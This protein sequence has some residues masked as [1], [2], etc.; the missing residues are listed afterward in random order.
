[1]GGIVCPDLAWCVSEVSVLVGEWVPFG[2]NQIVALN[3]KL[4]EFRGIRQRGRSRVAWAMLTT[5]AMCV[6]PVAPI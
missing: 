1:M 5:R 4:G 3:D 6:G 2:S